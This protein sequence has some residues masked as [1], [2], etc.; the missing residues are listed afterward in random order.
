MAEREKLAAVLS[1]FARTLTT[2]FPVQGILDHLVQ[3]IVDVVTVTSA[4]VTLIS[5]GRAP[6]YVAASSGAALRFEQLQTELRQ[7][8]CILAAERGEPVI[9]PD[10]YFDV[11]FPVFG[12]SAAAGGLGAVFAFPLRHGDETFGALDLYRDTPGELD[13]EDLKAAQTLADVAAAFV[14]N[15]QARDAA[16][17]TTELLYH[18]S[19]HDAL[20][21]LPNRI[22]LQERIEHAARRARR[23]HASAAIIFGDLDRFKLIN[24]AHGH[25]VGD[26]LLVA[27]AGRLSRLVRPGDTLAR[28][29]GDEFVFL[30]EDLANP[31]DADILTRRIKEAFIP[32]FVL[33]SLRLTIGISV[34]VA[35]SGPGE[36]VSD[37]M[38]ARADEAMYRAKRASRNHEEIIDLRPTVLE[39]ARLDDD[40]RVAIDGNGL[41]VVYQPIVQSS[42]GA[43]SCV[44]ALLRWTHP[45]RGP[46]PPLAVIAVAERR[47]WMSEVGAWVL[48]RSCED[49]RRWIEAHPGLQLDLAVNVCAAQLMDPAFP[50]ILAAV[51]ARTDTEPAALVIEVTEHVLLDDWGAAISVLTELGSLGI[52]LALDDFGTG[53]SSLSYLR[54]LPVQAVK[55]DKSFIEDLGESSAAKAILAAVTDLSHVLGLT[56][57]AE[58]VENERQHAD[59]LAL[60]CDSAQGF[61]YSGPMSASEVSAVLASPGANPLRLPRNRGTA[62]A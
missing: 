48:E 46:V 10:L 54:R 24:D 8:P 6:H 16:R 59:V 61:Y 13:S 9:V 22:L 56:V 50:E 12:P 25:H 62:E 41:H 29:S 30:C 58:G 53:Y 14:L 60:G 44:E 2:D 57:I 52:R 3:S 23:S 36:D 15:A 32:P 28:V 35:F 49:R 42:D 21:G 1:E 39:D 27:V 31:E 19:M 33:G 26:Q 45:R 47:G 11:R 55:V 40:L 20:T 18:R 5:E 51:L 43:V 17:V 38:V 34:G 37:G 4:G 7:G